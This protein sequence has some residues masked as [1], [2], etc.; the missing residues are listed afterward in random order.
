[1][2]SHNQYHGS[3]N[4][5]DEG[6][7]TSSGTTDLVP[8][9]YCNVYANNRSPER[10]FVFQG[11]SIFIHQRLDEKV[12]IDQNTG[13]VVWDGVVTLW[14]RAPDVLMG[15]KQ[16]STSIDIWSAGCIFAE[17]ASGRPLF[18]GSSVKDQLLKIFKILGTPTEET[19]TGVSNFPE[20]RSDFPIYNP[21]P[22][23]TLVPKLDANG[24]DLLIRLVT[25]NPDKRISADAALSH[26]YFDEL[27]QREANSG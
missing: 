13:N 5:Q 23:E 19:W 26:P 20:Y 11:H 21:I 10:L 16:Y 17:M 25:Y 27:R 9:K 2:S 8:W 7:R 24:I 6:Q 3:E 22:L 4:S 18:P 15:S 14:Y 1:M 12:T